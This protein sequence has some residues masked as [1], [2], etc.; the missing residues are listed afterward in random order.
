M[1]T[2][3]R[4]FG[5]GCVR[6]RKPLQIQVCTQVFVLLAAILAGAIVP[7]AVYWPV[8]ANTRNEVKLSS[9]QLRHLLSEMDE[10]RV[11]LMAVRVH[12]RDNICNGSSNYSS[13]MAVA[14][15]YNIIDRVIEDPPSDAAAR[16]LYYQLAY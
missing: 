14:P 4:V 7:T 16:L 11:E 5:C 12:Q 15:D 1:V 2:A 9:E 13:A 8:L 10:T 6:R 3:Y